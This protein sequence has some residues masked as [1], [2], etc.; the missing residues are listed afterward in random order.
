LLPFS[1]THDHVAQGFRTTADPSAPG[2]DV[3]LYIGVGRTPSLGAWD[4]RPYKSGSSEQAVVTLTQP[5]VLQIGIYGY[6]GGS[7]VLT[8]SVAQ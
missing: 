6:S 8:G 7:F 2:G 4:Y 3:D 1:K 5:T